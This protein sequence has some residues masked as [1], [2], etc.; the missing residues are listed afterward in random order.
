MY[1][2]TL[3][4]RFKQMSLVNSGQPLLETYECDTFKHGGHSTMFHN[5]AQIY[6]PRII[7]ALNHHLENRQTLCSCRSSN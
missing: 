6:V 1:P 3:A 2:Y 4:N 7:K 5:G